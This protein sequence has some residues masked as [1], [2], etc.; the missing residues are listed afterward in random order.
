MGSTTDKVSGVANQALAGKATS[1]AKLQAEDLAQ[2]AKGKA[3][4]LAGDAK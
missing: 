3:E 4:K 2:Q 1:S